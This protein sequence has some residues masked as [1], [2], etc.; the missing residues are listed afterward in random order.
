MV[1]EVFQ[2]GKMEISLTCSA[3]LGSCL[4][5]FISRFLQ[6][7]RFPMVLVCFFHRIMTCMASV[8]IQR[9]DLRL[10]IGLMLQLLFLWD[11][12]GLMGNI[13]CKGNCHIFVKIT[14]QMLKYNYVNILFKIL[15]KIRVFNLENFYMNSFFL[16]IY[17]Y[18][19]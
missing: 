2:R 5:L 12:L 7:P 8:K 3:L 4:T 6:S 18:F 19:T 10:F 16:N 13:F 17:I 1:L 9:F 11:R 14:L 15:K